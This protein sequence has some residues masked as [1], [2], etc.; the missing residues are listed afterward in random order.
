MWKSFG[1]KEW[2]IESYVIEDVPPAK[3]DPGIDLVAVV[4]KPNMAMQLDYPETLALQEVS[5]PAIIAFAD[6]LSVSVMSLA[7]TGK[8]T[9]RQARSSRELHP[10]SR[11]FSRVSTR[12]AR[13]R[14]TT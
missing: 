12:G 5:R 7:V 3:T 11:N 9:L 1:E 14:R 2:Y 10:E 13:T 8:T 4:Y 6:F